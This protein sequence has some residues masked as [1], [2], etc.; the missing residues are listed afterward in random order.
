MML[1]PDPG[2][3]GSAIDRRNR[4]WR[5][6]PL[7][8]AW[9]DVNTV[10]LDQFFT[11]P[12]IALSCYQSLLHW[13]QVK[14]AEPSDYH[15]IEPAAGL[16]VFY[17]LLPAGRRH[18]IDIL[19]L[20]DDFLERDFLSWYPWESQGQYAVIGNPPFGYRAWLALA[21]ITHAARFADY[22]GLILPMAFQSDGKG[23]PKHRVRGLQLMHTAYLPPD[24]FVDIQGRPVK[25]NALWQVWR[26]GPNTL[27]SEKTC[28]RWVDLF[29][30]DLRKERLC[31][32]ERLHEA[33][34]FLQRTFYGEPP[35]LVRNFADVRYGCGYG[36]VIR[37]D[38]QD[39]LD[40]LN[41]TD[42]RKYSNLAAHNCRHISMY[43]IRRA[44]TDG[45]FI[46]G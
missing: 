5:G 12:E 43:H 16:G 44:L 35:A 28:D 29:T 10:G 7:I 21:F 30:V 46:D 1:F 45:G 37:D 41:C 31:G 18:G 8:P 23:S 40:L 34:Y 24:S 25:V 17:D 6:H 4:A 2:A 13:M 36:L 11:R 42:W 27:P 32:H 9:V 39:I 33:D 15:F 38:P 14:G 26:R 22:V 20:R 3:S 19:S